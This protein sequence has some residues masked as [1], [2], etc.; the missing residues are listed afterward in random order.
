MDKGTFVENETFRN[1]AISLFN[2]S[3]DL[4]DRQDRSAQDDLTMIHSAHASRYC[5]GLVGDHKQFATGE[6]QVSRVYA[7]LEMAQS[8]LYHGQAS[9]DN[10]EQGRLSA[11][12]FAF[13]YEAIARACKLMGNQEQK[14]LYLKK[15][16]EISAQ[17]EDENDRTY[18]LGELESI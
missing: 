16:K 3:W 9:L 2:S 15:A 1:L 4:L 5:W 13:A 6:W 11:F 10:C 12:D 7:V 8:A 14:A 17:I 18:L